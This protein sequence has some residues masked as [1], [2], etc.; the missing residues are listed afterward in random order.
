[1][2]KIITAETFSEATPEQKQQFLQAYLDDTV[3]FISSI[4]QSTEEAFDVQHVADVLLSKD[5]K[6][7]PQ[8]LAKYPKVSKLSQLMSKNSDIEK[9]VYNIRSDALS[10]EPSF[11]VSAEFIGRDEMVTERSHKNVIRGAQERIVDFSEALNSIKKHNNTKYSKDKISPANDK[12][13]ENAKK[14]RGQDKSAGA[15]K[16]ITYRE[17]LKKE[18]LNKLTEQKLD[19]SKANNVEKYNKTAL[20]LAIL[21]DSLVYNKM[22][23][24][25]EKTEKSVFVSQRSNKMNP[26]EKIALLDK[27]TLL[28]KQ[29]QLE[30]SHK[31]LVLLLSRLEK[32]YQKDLI[33]NPDNQ[34]ITQQINVTS[35]ALTMLKAGKSMLDVT[36]FLKNN[37]DT[38]EYQTSPQAIALLKNIFNELKHFVREKLGKYQAD[39][40]TLSSSRH[41][42]FGKPNGKTATKGKAVALE[43]E[44][45]TQA[46]EALFPPTV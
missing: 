30:Q 19:F 29:E 35:N 39:E 31:R 42:M 27:P 43:I 3:L 6:L 16:A 24:S 7:S 45:F 14:I 38:L 25:G 23:L 12:A 32:S 26:Q 40:A 5:P 22:S 21:S 34:N 10:Y 2:T 18:D 9:A 37:K 46:V 44:G 28:E 15:E 36:E 1:M 33:S 17:S 41:T 11:H 8:L 4:R 20:E 13:I